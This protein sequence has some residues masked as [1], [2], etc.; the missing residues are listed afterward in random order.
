MQTDRPYSI[1]LLKEAFSTFNETSER[2]EQ[3]YQRL[4]SR[5]SALR[6]DMEEKGAHEREAR[7]ESMGWMVT[8]I[9]HDIR[10]PLGSIELISSLLRKELNDD[11][12]KQRLIEHIIYGVK[13]IDNILSNLLHFTSLPKPKFKMVSIEGIL[14]KCLDVMSYL[15]GKNQITVIQD[16]PADIRISCDETLM[17]QVFVNLFLNSL[18]AMTSGGRL[19]IKVLRKEE[20][21]DMEILIKDSGNGIN[22]EDLD[23]IFDPFFT[24][25]EKG[26]GLGLT[27][28][29]NIIKVHGGGINVYSKIGEG[30]LFIVK[31]PDMKEHEL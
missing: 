4:E 17:K 19:S 5:T 11:A 26:T 13:N 6:S 22:P 25:K 15:I 31:M 18:Q 16:I 14:K 27:I 28:V 8:K 12:D 29:H 9:V 7:L 24:T 23:R 30:T 20:G 2:L 3:F 10:N 21:S 1:E